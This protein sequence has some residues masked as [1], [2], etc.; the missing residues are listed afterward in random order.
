MRIIVTGASG[1]I[2]SHVVELLLK[3]GNHVLGIDNF[4]T[5]KIENITSLL[6]KYPNNFNIIEGD[7][8]ILPFMNRVFTEFKPKYVVHL[9]AQ[10]A[11]TTAWDNPV[12][13][14]MVNAIGTL[15]VIQASKSVGVEKI[16]F[17]STSAVY[18]ETNAKIKESTLTLPS[19]P[20]GIS[21]LAAEHYLLALYNN[22]TV[23][24]FGNV[25]GERQVP[26]GE[27]QLIPRMIKHFKYGDTFFIHGDG[28]QQRD[29]VYAGDVAQAVVNALYNKPGIF[30][31]S[32][33]Q[34]FS[35][36][37]IAG[38]VE[39]IYGIQ[40]YK[41]DHTKENDSRRSVCMNIS[42]A[43]NHLSWKPIVH[44]KEGIQKTVA[45]WEAR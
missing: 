3:S 25:Y 16:I 15:Y 2:A 11:I 38:I 6:E 33:G 30:N 17:S 1:F 42:E 31:V 45:W 24:R 44:I 13:D 4:T 39:G 26:I 35:V 41:W 40:G 20:Y 21:K 5:G 43:H 18:R 7:I 19:N 23:L 10:A 29:F 37:D 8:C 14:L 12:K 22:A 28:K 36:N 34:S 32:S 9:A 27:N